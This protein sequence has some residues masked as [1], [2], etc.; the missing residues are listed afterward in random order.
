MAFLAAMGA[1]LIWLAALLV[2]PFLHPRTYLFFLAADSQQPLNGPVLDYVD[3]DWLALQAAGESLASRGSAIAPVRLEN[4]KTK[5]EMSAL[6]ADLQASLGRS[7]DICILYVS[8]AGVCE[9]ETA[10]LICSDFRL[11]NAEKG[12]YDVAGLL[13]QIRD[14]DAAVK[15]LI[16]DVGRI[17]YDPRLGAFTDKFSSLLRNRVQ[18]LDDPRL[19]VFTSNAA[20]EQSHVSRSLERSVFSYFVTRGLSGAADTDED[21]FVSLDELY[22]YV[23]VNVAAVVRAES[24]A[25]ASQTP[26]LIWGGGE[27]A[28]VSQYPRLLRVG[29]VPEQSEPI[30]L[31]ETM[32][33]A[34][35]ASRTLS[36]YGLANIRE[37]ETLARE[38][39]GGLRPSR[40]VGGRLGYALDTAVFAPAP[41]P[42]LSGGSA[43]T[44]S[45]AAAGDGAKD[46]SGAKG[47]AKGEGDDGAAADPNPRIP[48]S[49]KPSWRNAGP[50]Y[51]QKLGRCGMR[52]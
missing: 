45:S 21:R 49:V 33:T 23:S 28:E 36:Y 47:D 38:A 22:R 11:A 46:G 25:I 20:G 27:V 26:E 35:A 2:L 51:W 13:D 1:L 37:P 4:L 31:A 52:C 42:G 30:E 29:R 41:M 44:D 17:G 50:R 3:R 9:D 7:S 10:Y 24:D 48:R 6:G 15:V 43:A 14:C 12:R 16:L 18:E 8:A 19:W 39:A 32:Q 34:Q 5:E 40:V